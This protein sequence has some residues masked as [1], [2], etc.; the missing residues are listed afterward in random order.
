MK[1][2]ASKKSIELKTTIPGPK[3]T[4]LL[5]LKEQHVPRGPFNTMMTF[6]EKGEGALLTDVDGNTFIDLAGAIGSMNAGHCPP[7][8]VEALKAQVDQYLHTCFHVMMY[9]PYIQLAKK[10]NEITPGASKR[11]PFS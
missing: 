8:V 6:A 11:K 7:K 1:T 5:E 2:E 3:A 9:E 10:L 4:E